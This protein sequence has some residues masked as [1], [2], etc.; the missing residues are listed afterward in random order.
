MGGSLLLAQ[1]ADERVKANLDKLNYKYEL[2][3]DGIFQFMVPVNERYQLIF[4]N[5]ATSMYD[6]MEFREI[7]TIIYDSPQRPTEAILGRLLIDNSKKKLGAWEMIVEEDKFYLIFTA[8]V[9]ASLSA[10]DM[11]STIDIV[12]FSA[13]AMEM[14]IYNDDN[15]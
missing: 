3:V 1:N 10:A 13:D 5:S 15:W 9:P 7:Y 4:V 2:K 11:K 6:Q 8:K 12:A 14:A